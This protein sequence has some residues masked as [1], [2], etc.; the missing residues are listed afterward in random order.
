MA[1]AVN[2]TFS[3]GGGQRPNWNGVNPAIAN[4]TVEKW[5]DTSVFSA[6]PAYSYGTSPRTF[7]GLR[8][9]GARNIDATISKTFQVYE[10]LRLQ[11]RGESFNFTNTPRFAPPNQSFGNALFGQA[12]SQLNQPRVVQFGLKLLW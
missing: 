9:A 5:F 10:K 7:N 8:A 2:N 11:F 6:A 3:Q 12:T 1:A 4:P